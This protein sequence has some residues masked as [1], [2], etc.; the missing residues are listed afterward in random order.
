MI[1]NSALL[2]SLK[3]TWNENMERFWLTFAPSF[4]WNGA[5]NDFRNYDLN[6]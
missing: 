2:K 3:K 4:Q 5:W 6:L 1:R